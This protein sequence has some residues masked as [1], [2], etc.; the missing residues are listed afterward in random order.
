M[1]TSNHF[2]IF[3]TLF[4]YP[5]LSAGCQNIKVIKNINS[6]I[7][8]ENR[9]SFHSP[10]YHNSPTSSLLISVVSIF[11]FSTFSVLTKICFSESCFLSEYLIEV[12]NISND[13]Y[14]WLRWYETTN[15]VKTREKLLHLPLLTQLLR[16][17][18]S[19]FSLVKILQLFWTEIQIRKTYFKKRRSAV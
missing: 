18:L 13:F 6:K 10:S 5:L 19:L 3:S 1:L 12:N 14:G 16:L 17:L 8:N 2:L 4:V 11:L 15:Q 7:H 9:T